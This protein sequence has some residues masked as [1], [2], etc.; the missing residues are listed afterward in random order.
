MVCEACKAKTRMNSEVRGGGKIT[1]SPSCIDFDDC[2]AG[3][4]G[5]AC[6]Y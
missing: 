2:L 6:W 1:K 3:N 4:G 5:C